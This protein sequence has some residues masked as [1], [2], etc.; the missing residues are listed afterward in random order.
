MDYYRSNTDYPNYVTVASSNHLVP[1]EDSR[2]AAFVPEFSYEMTGNNFLQIDPNAHFNGQSRHYDDL[3]ENFLETSHHDGPGLAALNVMSVPATESFSYASLAGM[4]GSTYGLKADTLG[5]PL[6]VSHS[7]HLDKFHR[8]GGPAGLL[9][10]LHLDNRNDGLLGMGRPNGRASEMLNNL[11]LNQGYVKE[12][13]N[14][15]LAFTQHDYESNFMLNQPSPQELERM[16]A[17]TPPAI[18]SEIMNSMNVNDQMVPYDVQSTQSFVQPPQQQSQPSRRRTRKNQQMSAGPSVSETMPP[19]P[20]E[21]RQPRATGNMGPGAGIPRAVYSTSDTTDPLNAEID[22]DIYIDTKDLCKRIAYELKQHSIPQAIFAER[23]LCRSQGTL[24]DLLRNPKPWNK[25][26]SGRETFR[27][28]FNWVQQPLHVRLSILDMY[29]GP[30]G[31]TAGPAPVVMSPPTP[32]QNAR[33]NSRSR[34]AGGGD[35]GGN[36]AKRPRL[37]FTDIQKRTLQAIFKETQRPSREMQQTI[38]EHLRLDMSTVSNFFMNARRRS[39]NGSVVDDEPAP[40]QQIRAITPPPH[41]PTMNPTNQRQPSSRSKSYKSSPQSAMPEHIDEAVSAVAH[42]R[43]RFEQNLLSGDDGNFTD[44]LDAG[45]EM[46]GALLDSSVWDSDD[47]K[48]E[49]NDD[50][51]DGEFDNENGEQVENNNF[52]RSVDN[53][54]TNSSDSPV[55]IKGPASA[56]GENIRLPVSIPSEFSQFWPVIPIYSIFRKTLI[57][58][59]SLQNIIPTVIQLCFSIQNLTETISKNCLEFSHIVFF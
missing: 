16:N 46:D 49:P 50:F 4:P 7:S 51:I 3:P 37:V 28:M 9:S 26:K 52:P 13:M 19:P 30:M 35:D 38:A 58:T 34:A 48:Q 6:R 53:H 29:K 55:S 47:V 1:V 24:S 33:Q 45:V 10:P 56:P 54:L 32:A 59:Y 8:F 20:T 39:R 14:P 18:S 41:S 15:E 36:S 57:F 31:S 43:D 25:L 12:E 21:Q 27:R 23:I 22:D 2:L 40:F 42:G 44:I 17:A 11:R 5:D